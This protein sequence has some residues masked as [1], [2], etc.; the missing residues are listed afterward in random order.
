M[1]N[2]TPLQQLTETIYTALPELKELGVGCE[3]KNP[4]TLKIYKIGI[5]GTESYC[6]LDNKDRLPLTVNNKITDYYI[7]VGKPITLTDVLRWMFQ[8][9][10]KNF[11][12]SLHSH[13]TELRIG[14]RNPFGKSYAW[15]NDN[16]L[17]NQS[18]ELVEFLNN[19]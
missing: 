8:L 9:K 18:I 13:S 11:D 12:F 6:I 1:P 5:F 3:I 7:V 10:E 19:L 15:N 17:E 4:V 16:L 14:E 2:L